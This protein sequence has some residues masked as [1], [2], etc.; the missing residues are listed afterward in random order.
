MDYIGVD[1]H[2]ATSY[3][4]R[5]DGKGKLISQ[6]QIFNTPEAIRSWAGTL[7]PG[8]RVAVEAV[9]HWMYLYEQLEDSPCEFF[10]SH[11]Q[12]TKAIAH[13]RLKND[14]VDSEMLAQLLRTGLLPEA[15]VP[16]REIR[17][18]RELLRLRAFLVRMRTRV[19]NRIRAVLLKTGH[20]YDHVNI[21]GKG[22]IL[23]CRGLEVR[24][25][26][27]RALNHLAALGRHYNSQIK[28]LEKVLE[29]IS[30]ETP[31]ALLLMTMP[32]IGI[33]SALLILSEI[34]EIERFRKADQLVSW[35]GLAPKNDRSAN[36]IYRGPI[37]KRGSKYVRW[38]LIE[39]AHHAIRLT[40]RYKS[41]YESVLK[42]RGRNKA[43]TAVAAS[44][45]RSIHWMLTRNEPFIDID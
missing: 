35:A 42:S 3:I 28:A 19:K 44:M 2:K 36:K 13:A 4:S 39:D 11:P 18:L 21:L 10:L 8:D 7:Q 26:Y 14:R 31:N 29:E 6:A 1:F 23:F 25:S 17:D 43:K 38:V 16:P 12:A 33:Y 27:R 15:Y 9:G 22:G 41:K 45:L 34:G 30:K 40:K 24:E 5:I 32:G 20:T 37:S